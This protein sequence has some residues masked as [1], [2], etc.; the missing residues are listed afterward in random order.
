MILSNL[1]RPT[2][3]HVG[4]CKGGNMKPKVIGLLAILSIVFLAGCET[5]TG[6]VA[7][8][9]TEG[10]VIQFDP[11]A[12]VCNPWNDDATAANR[13]IVGRLAYMPPGV[14]TDPN[15]PSIFLSGRPRQAS[16]YMGTN[17]GGLGMPVDVA[18]FFG[19]LFVPTRF[20]DRGFETQSG[21]LITNAAGNTLY[22][23]FGV[24]FETQLKLGPGDAEGDY[25]L[26]VLSD[27]GTVVYL[28]TPEGLIEHVSNDG[29]HPTKMGCAASPIHLTVGQKVPIRIQYYQGPRYH[30]SLVLMWRPWPGSENWQYTNS[31]DNRKLCGVDANGNLYGY[32][33]NTYYFTSSSDPG[34][35][36]GTPT[37]K[38]HSMLADGWKVLE[39]Q[40]FA[41]P[42]Y[43]ASN[44]C[45]PPP[46]PPPVEEDTLLIS[47]VTISNILTTSA[48]VTWVTS[49]NANSRVRVTDSVTGQTMEFSSP[50]YVTLR[51]IE[52][53]G[54]S[55]NTLYSLE[56]ES[57]SPA[58]QTATSAQFAFRTRR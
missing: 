32:A 23:W 31:A 10:D 49:I 46:P 48:S 56:V 29:E 18:I 16:A 13:G 30:I 57:V 6:G 34:Q 1:E 24:D 35:P 37:S 36:A 54:L 28:D 44:P 15:D 11:Q 26:A 47:G 53:T 5:P 7:E 25:Q 9:E 33:S 3:V 39:N 27:D 43:V 8:G 38:F 40:N 51:T 19:R 41:L 50:D 55:A 21:T 20:F 52:V 42:D 12:T 14:C 45:T 4:S 22:E 2:F 17:V 58:G